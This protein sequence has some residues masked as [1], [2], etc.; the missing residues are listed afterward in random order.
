[1]LHSAFVIIFVVIVTFENINCGY[2]LVEIED[3]SPIPS[4]PE[5]KP[6]PPNPRPTL[7]P[8]PSVAPPPLPTKA[9]GWYHTIHINCI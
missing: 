9:P 5:T 8:P 2:L 1:M 7:P 6:P 4:Q 3:D